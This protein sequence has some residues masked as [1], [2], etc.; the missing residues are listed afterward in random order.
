MCSSCS[1][2]TSSATVRGPEP[3]ADSWTYTVL[4]MTCSHCVLSVREEVAEVAGVRDV[5]VD[6][7]RGRL[8]VVGAVVS[9]EAVKGAVADAGYEVVS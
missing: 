7:A 3:T 4:G 1:T 2:P 6:L 8:T 5:E 9:D